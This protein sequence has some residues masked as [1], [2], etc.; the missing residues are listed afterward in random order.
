V[1]TST[2]TCPA[3][4]VFLGGG[5]RVTVSNASHIQKVQLIESYPTST[6]GTWTA[7]AVN[8]ANL[9]GSNTFSVQ[10]YAISSE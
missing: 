5:A 6:T 2:V 7:K 9:T 1:L 3:G 10:A 8:N 4:K